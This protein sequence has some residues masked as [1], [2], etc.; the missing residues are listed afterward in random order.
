[1]SEDFINLEKKPGNKKD[2]V[3]SLVV[4]ALV[5]LAVFG[6]VTLREH[7]LREVISSASQK[8]SEEVSQIFSTKE[9]KE[10]KEI[11][12]E[13]EE[14]IKEVEVEEKVESY[15]ETAR[16]GDGLT[17]LARRALSSHMEKE[18]LSLSDEQRIYIED[19]VQKNLLPEREEP[20]FLD[21]GEEVE[22]CVEL[23]EEGIELAENLSL[24]EI[25]NLKQYSSQVSF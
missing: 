7:S 10:E 9:E 11:E 18:D 4:L 13:K 2:I 21:I 12:D 14:D 15:K 3:T 5:F 23:I 1:M 17:H 25:N 22:I 6:F 16:K 24:D 20:R 19:Y 8:V